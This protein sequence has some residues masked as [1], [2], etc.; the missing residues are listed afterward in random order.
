M[1]VGDLPLVA[2]VERERLA[3]IAFLA[4]ARPLSV[5]SWYYYL[6]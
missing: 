6:R 4:T 1:L 5:S 2:V 3:S